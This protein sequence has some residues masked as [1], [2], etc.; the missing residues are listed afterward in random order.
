MTNMQEALR[1]LANEVQGCWSAY[2]SDLR[3]AMGHTN[4][5]I[6]QAR[7][8]DARAA[9]SAPQ[10]GDARDVMARHFDPK[11][12]NKPSNDSYRRA[13]RLIED[14]RGLATFKGEP[15]FVASPPPPAIVEDRVAEFYR[16]TLRTVRDLLNP[17]HGS[18]DIQV[19]EQFTD[20]RELDPPPDREYAVNITWQ[21]ERDLTKAVCI[22][23]N[24][25]RDES[26][27]AVSSSPSAFGEVAR[28]E[29]DVF[30][31]T[32]QGY[33]IT[34]EGKRGVVLQQ[35]GTRVVHVYGERW[36]APHR[37]TTNNPPPPP[38]EDDI[39]RAI[40][41]IICQGSRWVPADEGVAIDTLHKAARAVL[42]VINRK[43]ET[44][45]E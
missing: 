13:D 9:L 7:I 22:I 1:K 18:L 10:G 26:T 31:G 14:L 11:S 27:L 19:P 42:A 43:N 15:T 16:E 6:V 25:I 32:I 2:E 36:L 30:E 45:D 8:H 28:I 44:N 23:E 39:V 38:G 5:N 24:R 12:P 41:P 33:Y 4:Y 17:L 29:H 21:M 37:D 40:L 20:E 3:A 34:R 35:I